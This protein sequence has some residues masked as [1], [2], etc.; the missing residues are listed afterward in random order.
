MTHKELLEIAR[1]VVLMGEPSLYFADDVECFWLAEGYLA[2]SAKLQEAEKRVEEADEARLNAQAEAYAEIADL[3]IVVLNRKLQEVQ[4]ERDYLRDVVAKQA[5][6]ITEIQSASRGEVVTADIFVN[7]PAEQLDAA[8][9]C[10]YTPE[11]TPVYGTKCPIIAHRARSGKQWRDE[12]IERFRAGDRGEV[13]KRD[14][15][16]IASAPKDGT[17]IRLT[18]ADTTVEATGR[19]THT[20]AHQHPYSVED[21]RD[22]KGDDVLHLPSHWRPVSV[23]R[24]VVKACPVCRHNLIDHNEDYERRWW[25]SRCEEHFDEP[26]L[27]QR[28]EKGT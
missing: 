15:I 6:R 5:N 2:L 12:Y 22:I 21:W 25:C 18:W 16:P 7:E 4:A 1:E 9:H 10:G 27:W 3:D 24:E 20:D 23:S 19:W 11:H 13:V 28:I 14:W 17:V 8:C 26:A